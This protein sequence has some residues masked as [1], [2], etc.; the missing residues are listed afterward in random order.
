MEIGYSNVYTKVFG[1]LGIG[2]LLTFAV[3]FGM[4]SYVD[5]AAIVGF[6]TIS[7]IAE[8][9]I[10]I[11][12]GLCLQKLSP[13]ACT[14]LYLIYC[15]VSGVNFSVIF[16]TYRVTS[17]AYVFLITAAIFGLFAFLGK[18]SKVDFRKLGIYLLFTLLAVIIA[19]IVNVFVGSSE[20]ELG[21]TIICIILFMLYILY[22]MK[23]IPNLVEVFGPEKAAVYG[24]FQLYID[25]INLFVD[26]LRLLGKGKD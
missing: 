3:A 16:L 19:S 7:I 9:G 10:A 6:S 15:I 1:W 22:D 26:I 14:V 12:M 5:R 18:V 24:A 8:L 17:I 23:V 21:L 4:S 13:T 25:F 2:L 11:V 20:L